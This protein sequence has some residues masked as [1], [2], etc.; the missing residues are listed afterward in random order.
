MLLF[1]GDSLVVADLLRRARE[2]G[3]I[4]FEQKPPPSETL[5]ERAFVR[6]K[7]MLLRLVRDPG[8]ESAGRW[9]D[10]PVLNPLLVPLVF[11]GFL[12]LARR[13]GRSLP[14]TL[15]IWLVA[16]ALLP[17]TLGG[18]LPRRAALLVPGVAAVA[19]LPLLPLL[20][21]ARRPIVSGR[22]LA[23]ALAGFVAA[24]LATDAHR[25]FAGGQLQIP[26]ADGTR[27]LR[28]LELVKALGRVPTDELVLVAAPPDTLTPLYGLSPPGGR[29]KILEVQGVGARS[30][31]N[32]S[33]LF[34]PPFTWL[35]PASRPVARDILT[36]VLSR[37]FVVSQE[38]VLGHALLRVQERRPDACGGRRPG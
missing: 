35:V 27:P 7:R 2:A 23:L 36:D 26:R 3:L 22:L 11:V 33:C 30:L 18:A 4:A 12:E 24:V 5:L 16:A 31:R 14:R 19:A 20:A 8:W 25:Y 1:H 34:E 37:D 21:H 15:A 29:N 10:G 28:V 13:A 32:T 17:A 38:S 9:T 6:A